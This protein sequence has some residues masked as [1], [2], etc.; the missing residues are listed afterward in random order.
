MEMNLSGKVAIVT[1]ASMGIGRAIALGLVEESVSVVICAR[2]IEPLEEVKKEIEEKGGNVHII[3]A[4][5]SKPDDISKIVGT[6]VESFGRLDIIVN[7]VGWGTV[8]EFTDLTDDTWQYNFDVNL[9]SSVRLSREAIPHMQKQ[10]GGR[11][12]NIAST[13]GKQPVLKLVDY[14]VMKGAVI[15]LTK[16]LSE[17]LAPD[18]ILV[19]SICP[20]AIRTPLW[21]RPGGTGETL[22]KSLGMSKE[23]A[24]QWFT[25]QN[26]SLGR[27]GKP[28]EIADTVVFL[29]SER[30]SFITGVSI[31][32]DGGTI[33]SL[34]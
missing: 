13:C 17:E 31:N 18:N 29:A 32:V 33:K 5:L 14:N 4:D 22:G 24:M 2:G 9:M 27:F 20:G 26:I 7:N 34:I 10:G 6:A 8:S 23:D 16:S 19:N 30:A 21:D 25:E 3:S 28:E 11:I 15:C 12:I 1:G